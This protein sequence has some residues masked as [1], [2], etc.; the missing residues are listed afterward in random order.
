MDDRDAFGR[1]RRAPRRVH[2]WLLL[3]PS[4]TLLA[5]LLIVPISIM[6]A[7][8]FY[9]YVDIGVEKPAFV[10]SNWWAF[11][12]DPYYHY[13]LWKTARVAF[14]T[15][16][17]C[18]LVGYIPAYVIATTKY[19]RRWVLMLLLLL[20][21]W[22][23]F[24][25]R[26]MSWIHVLGTHGAVNTLLMS[27]GLIDKPLELLYREAAVVMGLVHFLLP[28]T[29]LNIFVSIESS[30]RT[31]VPVARTLGATPLQAFLEV[32]LPLSMP[33]VA[34]GALLAFVLA[35]G[36]Y[37]TPLILGGPDDFLFG[38]L[39]YGT[40]MTELNWPLGSVLAIALTL[41]LGALIMVYNRFFGL[42]RLTRGLA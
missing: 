1:Q 8:S 26:T 38:N 30:D 11:L 32:T 13:A 35:A 37:V 39:I 19:P 33:G 23:S 27:L 28:F 24:V 14:I 18:V 31:L 34:T 42:E 36:S 40:V 16:V 4:L 25:I 12:K 2:V 15:T 7:Y 6:L 10:L 20:P 9:R 5:A 29:I 21:F 22:I 41:I 17:I 3:T